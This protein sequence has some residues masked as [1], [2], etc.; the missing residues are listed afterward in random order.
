MNNWVY[1]PFHKPRLVN[2]QEYPVYLKNGWFK[3][4][5]EIPGYVANEHGENVNDTDEYYDYHN[6]AMSEAQ[7]LAQEDEMPAIKKRGRPPKVK[8]PEPTPALQVEGESNGL[9]HE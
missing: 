5:A 9:L 3:T 6:N 8:V 7:E 2:D 4:H 1:H